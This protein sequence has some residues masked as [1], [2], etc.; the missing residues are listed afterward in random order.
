VVSYIRPDHIPRSSVIVSPAMLC[1][2]HA[3][4]Q[5]PW[6]V[7]CGACL[8]HCCCY[9][10]VPETAC[11]NYTP[12]LSPPD[13][14]LL[15]VACLP[16]LP[17]AGV[18]SPPSSTC[19]PACLPNLRLMLRPSGHILEG[20]KWWALH[21]EC[22]HQLVFLALHIQGVASQAAAPSFQKRPAISGTPGYTSMLQLMHDVQPAHS[23][24]SAFT[25]IHG[26]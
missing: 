14:T 26:E 10:D 25:Y 17:V 21:P 6:C 4:R 19:L 11:L 23:S 13:T 22:E 2:R 16:L 15:P 24:S 7:G 5:L 9:W 8:P 3:H 18:I 1:A 20:R 12:A